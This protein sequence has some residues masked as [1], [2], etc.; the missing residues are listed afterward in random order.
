MP[1]EKDW[2][3]GEKFLKRVFEGRIV[4]EWTAREITFQQAFK[5]QRLVVKFVR[6]NRLLPWICNK[7]AIPSPILLLRHP[8]A[9]ISSQLNYGWKNANRPDIPLF[10]KEYPRFQTALSETEGDVE[11]LAALWALDQLP[12]L[13]EQGVH[14][15]TTITYEELIL[16]PERT[17]LKIS[18]KWNIKID[19]KYALSMLKK[20]SSVVSSSGI[21]GINGWKEIMSEDQIYRIIKTV[22]SFG[23]SFY[24]ENNEAE[25][26]KLYSEDL[27]KCIQTAGT[28]NSA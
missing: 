16:H 13:M 5:S 17:L 11:F 27:A 4:N 24:S 23:L 18:E 7:F 1:R 3:E 14:P 28:G 25:Y 20:P 21:S 6:A 19:T 22:N 10:L 8:C 12:A 2:P 26:S 9:V 15:W